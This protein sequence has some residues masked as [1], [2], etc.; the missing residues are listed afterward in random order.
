[1]IG[2]RRSLNPFRLASYALV[3]YAFGHTVGAVINVPRFGAA[4]DEVV[5]AMQRVHV[6]VQ[7]ADA[8]WYGF[9]RG[10]GYFVGFYLLFSAV[11]AW[12]LGGMT[13]RTRRALLP[14]AWSLLGVQLACAPLAFIY[15]FP[16]PML[17]QSIV[18]V[19]LTIGC[20]TAN[21]QLRRDRN[22]QEQLQA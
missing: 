13:D 12:L 18:I 22:A 14:I 21:H 1:M 8:T 11:L 4:S 19:L 7:G 10:F 2:T 20:V 15:F 3:L 5:A 17:F 16:A 9:Y 6:Q